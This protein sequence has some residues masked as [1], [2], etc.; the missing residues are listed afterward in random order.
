MLQSHQGR[1]RSRRLAAVCILSAAL[2]ACAPTKVSITPEQ[3]SLEQ[4]PQP[5]SVLVYTFAVSPDEVQLTQGIEPAIAQAVSGTP[6]TEQEIQLGHAVAQT[7]ADEIVSQ[8]QQMGLAATRA[9]GQPPAYG[10]NALVQGQLISIDEGNQTE[11]VV[12]GLGFGRSNVAASVQ[13][14]SSNAG[15]ITPIESVTVNAESGDM[16]GA[17]ET[18]G[19]G[20]ITGHL[21]LSA[22]TT[23]VGQ[24]ANYGLSASASAEAKRLG[25]KVATELKAVFQQQGWLP[26]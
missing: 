21:A 23:T 25:D 19:V 15:T 8:V 5:S 9:S 2:A 16:P 11:R 1:L 22:A 10:N 20:G 24:F 7:I 6:R 17:A 3:G 14:S 4:L 12:I 26:L 13:V 18:M